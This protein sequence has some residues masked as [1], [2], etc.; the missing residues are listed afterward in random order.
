MSAKPCRDG[1]CGVHCDEPG[2]LLYKRCRECRVP[3]RRTIDGA[4]PQQ[5]RQPL[6]NAVRHLR[7][8][9]SRKCQPKSSVTVGIET[10]PPTKRTLDPMK[11]FAWRSSELT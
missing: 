4:A 11:Q 7:R 10:I 9:S 1:D 2:P 3:P 6:E 5:W 8:K